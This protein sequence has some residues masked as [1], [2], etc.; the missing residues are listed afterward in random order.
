M[1]GLFQLFRHK[2]VYNRQGV[3]QLEEIRPAALVAAKS[4]LL[5]FRLW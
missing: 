3:V 5:R 4:A 1:G 2:I